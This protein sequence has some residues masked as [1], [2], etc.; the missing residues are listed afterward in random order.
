MT[1]TGLEP[2]TTLFVKENLT[3]WLN[4]PNNWAGLWLLIC[5]V[6]LTV[7]FYHVTYA[8]QSESTLYLCLN[9]KEILAPSRRDIWRLS[10]CK[11]TRTHNHFLCKW[12]LNHLAKVTILV[13]LSCDYLSLCCIWLYI[14]VM[15]RTSFRVNSISIFA[16]ISKKPQLK[17]SSI[18]VV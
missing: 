5:T 13:D 3:I 18:S 15:L 6:Y 1:A 2:T 16:W 7:C 10:D 4:S 17:T 14:L 8:F 11:S 9:V 12:T